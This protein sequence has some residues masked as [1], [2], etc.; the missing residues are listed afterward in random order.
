MK[1]VCTSIDIGTDTIKIIV[2]EFYHDNVYVLAA[3]T[4]KAKGMRKGLIVDPNLL[5]NCIKDGI[6][7][8]N[9]KLG[10]EIKKT[11]VNIPDYNT[12]FMYVTGKTN[13]DNVVDTDCI[14]RVIKDSIYNKLD[15]D[16]ELVTVIPL[17]F[18]IDNDKTFEKPYGEYGNTIEV[19]GIMVS[20]PKKNIYSVISAVEGAG[21]EIVDL[22]LSGLSDYY[23]VK[24]DKL[25]GKIGAIINLGHETTNV[26]I[27]NKG[28]LMNTETIQLGGYN[29]EKDIS[30]MFGINIVDARV[31]KEKFSACHKRFTNLNETFEIKNNLGEIIKLNQ[32]EV[33]EITMSRL[34]EILNLAKKQILL[35]TK[36]E[37]EYIVFTGGL[38]EIKSFKNLVYEIFGKNVII[39]SVQDL[40]IRDNKYTS[41]LGS[42][43]YFVDK[44]NLRGKEYTMITEE[45]EEL[46][47]SSN[48]K[49]RKEK[50]VV[51]KIF[52]GFLKTKEE[53]NE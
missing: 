10:F 21:L 46:L 8:I 41:A 23:E 38:T 15:D 20:V 16:Y 40:G 3:T 47:L 49:K 5:I 22:T 7:I 53:D 32:L 36:K 12:K 17:E 45:D 18:I 34:T 50:V 4:V 2:G 1:K 29:I 9:H 51:S 6:S 33:T 52:K 11:I 26:S 37:I 48:D 44:M 13:I 31:I 39:Y 19:K 42:I 24:N 30:Y 43:K 35:L 25:E 27:I 14:N 28:K